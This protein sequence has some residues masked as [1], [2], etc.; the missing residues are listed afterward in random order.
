MR[1]FRTSGSV[2][3]PGGQLPGATRPSPLR[4]SAIIRCTDPEV[5]EFFTNAVTC[6]AADLS[7]RLSYSAP[8]ATTLN[9]DKYSGQD[10]VPPA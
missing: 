2:G 10:Y 5:G 9:R 8:L 3:A 6:D 4:G 1:E 7:N